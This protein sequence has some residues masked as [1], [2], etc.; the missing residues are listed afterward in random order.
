MKDVIQ[1]VT[2]VVSNFIF[3]RNI[4]HWMSSFIVISVFVVVI[5]LLAVMLGFS[6]I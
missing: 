1:F 6:K 4:M 5:W 3:P 2:D